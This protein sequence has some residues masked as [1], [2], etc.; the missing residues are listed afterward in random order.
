MAPRRNDTFLARN[1]SPSPN[2]YNP[3]FNLSTIESPRNYSIGKSNRGTLANKRD[4]P[5]P[6]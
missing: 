1:S 2:H 3:K 4:S 5:G 6:G